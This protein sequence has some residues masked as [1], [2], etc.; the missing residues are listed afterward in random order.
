MKYSGGTEFQAKDTASA[1][2]LRPNETRRCV[3]GTERPLCLERSDQGYRGVKKEA[4]DR[5]ER[6]LQAI[7]SGLY[8]ETVY[9]T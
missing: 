1:K 5:S 3:C 4:E 2:A 7:I 8:I 9:V 6:V